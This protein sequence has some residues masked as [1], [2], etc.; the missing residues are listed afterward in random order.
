MSTNLVLAIV[1]ILGLVCL[2]LLIKWAPKSEETGKTPADTKPGTDTAT[3]PA[4]AKAAAD[5]RAKAAAEASSWQDSILWRWLGKPVL[6]IGIICAVLYAAVYA[7]DRHK[8]SNGMTAVQTVV[9]ASPPPQGPKLAWKF[10][11]WKSGSLQKSANNQDAEILKHIRGD[12][13]YL[14]FAVRT[15]VG[16]QATSTNFEWDGLKKAGFL[17]NRARGM[18][19]VFTG[20]FDLGDP[21]LFHGNYQYDGEAYTFHLRQIVL[22]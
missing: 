2:V 14:W 7:L 22:R 20:D 17:E 15:Y 11:S 16:G 1:C 3:D 19:T 4:A 18:K 8:W 10:D 6:V 12:R 13:P 5:A 9:A 21:S